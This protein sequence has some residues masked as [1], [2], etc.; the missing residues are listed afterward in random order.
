[1]AYNL[2][3]WTVQD[4]V[5]AYQLK[6][7]RLKSVNEIMPLNLKHNRPNGTDFILLERSEKNVGRKK[8]PNVGQYTRVIW[9]N[10][11]AKTCS[12]F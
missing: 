10:E 9:Y 1:M 3:Y 6:Q 8:V 12:A 7:T 4:T 2:T 11:K 5:T